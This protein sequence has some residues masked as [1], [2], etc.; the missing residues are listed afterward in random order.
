VLPS[1]PPSSTDWTLKVGDSGWPVYALQT[2]LNSVAG[3][4]L[5]TDGAFGA[6]TDSA[7]TALQRA[8]SLLADGIAG[9]RT[10]E[11]LIRLRIERIEQAFPSLPDGLLRGK[12]QTESGLLLGAVNWSVPGGVDCGAAQYRVYG[13]PY[14][15]GEADKGASLTEAFGQA[16]VRMAAKDFL[17]RRDSFLRSGA[18]STGRHER[19]GR[20][21]ALA[22]NWPAGAAY[23]ADHGHAPNPGALATWVPVGLRFPDG[24]PVRTRQEWCEFYAMGGVHGEG[25][26]TRYVTSWT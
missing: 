22:H 16:C 18:W 20:L 6:S 12:L 5:V 8:R 21:A 11:E 3:A 24:A 14:A 4:G 19:S 26:T 13:P 2:F 15:Q 1:T 23:Y 10:Q 9:A 17:L 25:R 7:V